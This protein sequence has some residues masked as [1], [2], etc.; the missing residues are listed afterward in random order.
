MSTNKKQR[1]KQ[2]VNAYTAQQLKSLAAQHGITGA[3]TNNKKWWATQL[4]EAGADVTAEET[5]STNDNPDDQDNNHNRNNTNNRENRNN[6]RSNR[7]NRNKRKN[8]NNRN[9]RNVGDIGANESDNDNQNEEEDDNEKENEEKINNEPLT[10]TANMNCDISMEGL[11]SHIKPGKWRQIIIKNQAAIAELLRPELIKILDENDL[12]LDEESKNSFYVTVRGTQSPHRPVKLS[13]CPV[14]GGK[15]R[16]TW[17]TNRRRKLEKRVDCVVQQFG[18]GGILVMIDLKSVLTGKQKVLRIALLG[19]L[20]NASIESYNKLEKQVKEFIDEY[21]QQK[22][23]QTKQMKMKA[24]IYDS[25]QQE[26]QQLMDQKDEMDENEF[27]RRQ[28]QIYQSKMLFLS[29][30]HGNRNDSREKPNI[31]KEEVDYEDDDETEETV[32][33]DY[34]ALS[35]ED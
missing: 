19:E 23:E 34:S 10:V 2:L 6:N 1:I 9:N 32:D 14:N 12:K 30:D 28:L 31:D 33:E 13:N 7:S 17:I 29:N 27:N 4:V 8:P 22:R 18:G 24:K 5:S 15:Q 21:I 16:E 11:D 26:I 3:R 20:S 25:V 35:D